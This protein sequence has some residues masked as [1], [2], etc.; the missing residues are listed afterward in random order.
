M[1]VAIR[2][3]SLVDDRQELLDLLKRNLG[4]SQERRWEWRHTANPAGPAWSWCVYDQNT[5]ATVGMASLF[6]RRMLLDGK[7]MIGGQVGD[8]VI[9]ATH[10]SLG[11]A[12]LLQRA[13]FQPVDTGKIPFCYDCPPHD[14]GMSTFLRLGMRPNCEVVRYALLL[15]GDQFIEKRLGKR[16]CTKPAVAASNL[17]LKMRRAN[18]PMPGLEISTF[19]SRFDDEFSRLDE[20][21]S[22][23]GAIRSS[24]SATVLNWRY[25]DDPMGNDAL[26]NGSTGRYRYLVARRAGELVAFVVFFIQTD[27]IA[28]IVDLFGRDLSD[29]GTSL[30]EAVIE[31][32]RRENVNSVHGFCSS[33][34][35]LKPLFERVGFRPRERAVRVVAHAKQTDAASN[36][37]NGGLRWIFGQVEIL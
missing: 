6:P 16:V 4:G 14:A 10:R 2:P 23:S 21:L 35:E 30:L 17:F 12:V 19:D 9:D 13:T 31:V 32:C 24:R 5:K 36:L 7:V 33:E 34:S 11:P 37:L 29:A 27:A 28:S 18:R 1:S 8:F 25:R 15:R 3:L 20:S 22:S 26:P